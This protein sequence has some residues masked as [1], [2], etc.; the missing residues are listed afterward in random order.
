M[1][2][3][4]AGDGSDVAFISA[5]PKVQLHCH[6]EGTLQYSSLLELAEQQ[7]LRQT[8]VQALRNIGSYNVRS[9]SQFFNAFS[10]VCRVLKEPNDYR[11]LAEEFINDARRQNVVYGEI[12]IAPSLWR[13]FHPDL[14]LYAA[15][16]AITGAFR[17]ARSLGLQLQ[18]IFGSPRGLGPAAAWDVCELA[19]ALQGAGVV[20]VG[21]GG[22]ESVAPCAVFKAPFDFARRNGLHVVAH[23]GE[24][25][26]PESIYSAV[27]DLGAERIGHGI[28]AVNDI[29]LLDLL[30]KKRIPLEICQTSNYVTGAVPREAAS[31]PLWELYAAGMET[32]ID[33]D[34]PALLN[35]S[36]TEEYLLV[37]ERGALSLVLEL[38]FKAID[39][40][41][42][43]DQMKSQMCEMLKQHTATLGS[44][45]HNRGSPQPGTEP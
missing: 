35:T 14:D 17:R 40:T 1:A 10:L 24:H 5:M 30:R 27:V 29:P 20:A 22:F 39:A 23:A 31:H 19:V 4:H 7:G 26:G 36:I 21:L 28:R 43:N 15:I 42:A 16:Q 32:V 11:R 38:A 18:L 6:L 34:D 2:S 13:H 8:Y 12:F 37:R 3:P 25:G 45:F 9:L 41:F 33:A 44:R